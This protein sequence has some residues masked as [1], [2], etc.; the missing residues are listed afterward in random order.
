MKPASNKSLSWLGWLVP[1][2]VILALIKLFWVFI[3]LFYLPVAGIDSGKG[4]RG[5]SL[6]QPYRL[7]SNEALKRTKKS[8]PKPRKQNRLREMKLLGVYQGPR[9]H[10]AVISKGNKSYVVYEGEKVLGYRI[11]SVEERSVSLSRD[12]K[13]YR[14]ELVKTKGAPV[15][16]APSPSSQRKAGKKRPDEPAIVDDDGNKIIPRSLLNDYAKDLD[17][18]RKY[19]RMVPYKKDGALQGF[20]VRFVKRG[21]DFA[22]LGLKRGD[23]ITGINGEAIVDYSTP[24]E[25]MKNIDTLE[26]LTLQIKRGNEELEIEYEVR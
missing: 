25:L 9:H 7:A 19:I 18:I 24:M 16:S 14:L 8:R 26:G 5:K 15:V 22:K 11:D 6:Y 3:E 23:I 2:L 20:K 1:V 4:A 13:S 17:K 10:I 21:S 12:G